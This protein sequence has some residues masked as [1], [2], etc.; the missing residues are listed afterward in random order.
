MSSAGGL[1]EQALLARLRG[2]LVPAHPGARG[3]Y[4]LTL[5]PGCNRLRVATAAGLSMRQVAEVLGVQVRE[6]QSMFALDRGT[7]F[8]ER[9][10]ESGAARLLE[11]FRAERAWPVADCRVLDLRDVAPLPGGSAEAAAAGLA[12]RAAATQRALA[13]KAAGDPRA[14]NVLVQPVLLIQVVG[15]AYPII[16]DVLAAASAEPFYTPGEAKSFPDRG[17]KT[18]PADVAAAARQ[19]AVAVVGLRQWAAAARRPATLVGDQAHLVFARPGSLQPTL[20]TQSVRHEVAVL[21]R[22]LATAP[23]D[24]REVAAA[25]PP[26]ATLADPATMEEL[27]T[28]YQEACRTFCPL[29]ENCKVQAI[30]AASPMLLGTAAAGELAGISDLRRAAALLFG[31]AVPTPEETATVAR[32]RA[33]LARDQRARGA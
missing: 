15:V 26:D 23:A 25:L 4:H 17:S 29:A 13:A 7:R 32:L 8:E 24:L 21:E 31:D 2:G 18:D 14:Y 6:G 28:R 10:Y 5:N 33:D 3:L 30:A 11:L 9:L 27:P 22:A 1:E 19:A 20:H 12:R 16:P